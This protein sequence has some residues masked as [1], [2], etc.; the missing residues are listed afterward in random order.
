LSELIK[1]NCGEDSK[2]CMLHKKRVAMN[3]NQKIG[4]INTY[5][6]KVYEK[7]SQNMDKEV[8]S[9]LKEKIRPI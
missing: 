8:V 6:T 4:W 5:H 3:T 7:L 9:W 1:N 2:Y